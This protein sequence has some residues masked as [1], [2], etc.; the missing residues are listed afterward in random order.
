MLFKP[1]EEISRVENQP[2]QTLTRYFLFFVTAIYAVMAILFT[3]PTVFRL[4]EIV[5]GE[6]GGDAWQM[7]WNLWWVKYALENGQFPLQ[8]NLLF[9]PEGTDLYVHALNVWNGFVSLPVQYLFGGGAVGAI[10]G[11]NFIVWLSLTLAGLGA[12]KL[13]DYL[14]G[15]WWGAFFAGFAFA[16]SAYQFGHLL[17]HLNLVSSK[18]IPFF[19]LY[20][21]KTLHESDKWRKNVAL[22]IM[23]LVFNMLLEL[24]YVVFLVFFCGLYLLYLSLARVFERTKLLPKVSLKVKWG[25]SLVVGLGFG[26]LSLPFA[27]GVVLEFLTNPNVVP[28]RQEKIY[29]A[30]LLAYFYP[31]PFHPLWGEAMA[32]AIK[33]FTATLIEKLV[34][35]TFSVYWLILLGVIFSWIKRKPLPVNSA[36]R[37][38][39]L[40]LYIS[41]GFIILSFGPVLHINGKESGLPLPAALIYEI[42]LLNITRVPARFSI[43]AIL[44]LAMLAAWG[45]SRFNGWVKRPLFQNLVS[46]SLIGLLLFELLPVPYITTQYYV[47]EFY[48]RLANDPAKYAVLDLPIRQYETSYLQAQMTHKKP[49]AGGYISRN[50]V[51]PPYY[52]VPVF[53][54]FRTLA[55]S[56]KPD[57]LPAQKLTPETLAYFGVRYVVVHTNLTKGDETNKLLSLAY[58]LFPQGPVYKAEGLEVFEV[59][60]TVSEDI[61]FY[62]P[63]MPDWYEVEG[64]ANYYSR[65]AKNKAAKLD[66]WSGKPRN[67]SLSFNIWSFHV[68]HTVEIVLERADGQKM[69][70]QKLEI[71]TEPREVKLDFEIKPGQNQLIFKIE[72]KAVRPSE[73]E[74]V[75]DT[76]P[77]TIAVGN[78]KIN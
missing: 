10:A 73:L 68:P 72:G 62:N 17:G 49:L 57:F 3:M 23:F 56:T 16:F 65:W 6:P 54:E 31:S 13:A 25:R 77:L 4:T 36:P 22:A 58:K 46:F 76:R 45:L 38:A 66:L 69:S 26:V 24:Q 74:A 70:F 47:P 33:P 55:T 51:Y 34:F 19:I 43:M 37:S 15:D 52:G 41:L 9:F 7:V 75:P 1:S 18:F 32:R 28:L 60:G 78:I 61:F 67:I 14:W 5:P 50:P 39:W 35:P 40:W 8:T 64:S 12:F 27:I 2:K 63:V 53:Q 29:S 30:D 59:S 44:A 71:G 21:L 20:F 42:P 48:K 11:Y